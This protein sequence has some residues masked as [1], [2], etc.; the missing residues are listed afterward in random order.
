[1]NS[2]HL[3]FCALLMG[4]ATQGRTAGLTALNDSLLNLNEVVVTATRTPKLLKDVPYITKV[5]TADDI[6]KADAFNIQDLLTTIMPGI[7]FTFAMNQQT[8]LNMTGFGGNAVL[9]L[10]DGERMAGETMDNPDFSRL[11]LDDVE[12]IEVVKGAASSLYGSNA[13]GGVVNIITKRPTKP[14]SARVFGHW[15]NHNQQKYGGVIGAAGKK[16]QSL[17]TVQYTTIDNIN[18]PN[19]GD[20]STIFGNRT[21]NVKE[22]LTYQPIDKLLL[23]GKAGYF[24]RERFSSESSHDRYRDLSASLKGN[25]KFSATDNLELVYS[26]DEYDKSALNMNTKMDVRNYNNTQNIFRGLYNHTF[27]GV[28]TLTFGAD[29]M[30]DYL[31][32][33][34]FTDNG[35]HNQNTADAFAQM[36]WDI[37]FWLNAIGGL[38]YDYF[39]ASDASHVSAKVGVMAKVDDWRFRASY[40]GGFRA[41]TLKE[42]YMNFNMANIFM[43]YGN[44][45]LKPEKSDNY[46]VSVEYTHRNHTFSVSG[47]HNNFRNRISTL[48]NQTLNGM[49]YINTYNVKIYGIDA[50]AE[51]RYNCGIGW[52]LSYVYEHESAP[53]NQSYTSTTRPHTAVAR[54]DYDHNFRK[55]GFNVAI[56][57]RYLSSIKTQEYTTSTATG[58]TEAQDIKYPSYSIWKLTAIGR[59][60][61]GVNLTLAV[62]NLFNYKP[63]YYYNNSPTTEG[64][65]FSCGLSIDIDKLFKF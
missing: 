43:I 65:V 36:D 32:S 27:T 11:T 56:T 63:S 42:L 59:L 58:Q 37:T 62:D 16:L 7:E 64:A 34:Q 3:F 55:W 41:P 23:T 49:E 22:K 47:Y 39:S 9:F 13:V 45:D 60:K 31:M 46:Q 33:Y 15:S 26:F 51:G 18:L 52:K 30:H 6:A 50:D 8:T 17:T 54:L 38:R 21:W 29:Y 53:A 1:M 14:F 2:K 28:G 44:S 19:D 35:S 61:R 10:I 57:G 25:Y 4:M 40:A 48:W 5:Y 20:F 24:F 12:R